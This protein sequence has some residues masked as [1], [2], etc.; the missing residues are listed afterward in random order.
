[1]D[2]LA[3]EFKE[4]KAELEASKGAMD[5]MTHAVSQMLISLLSNN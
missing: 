2:N 4:I 5:S 3:K 1:M